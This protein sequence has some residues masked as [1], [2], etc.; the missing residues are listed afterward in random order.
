MSCTCRA[1]WNNP[2]L[3]YTSDCLSCLGQKAT[4]VEMIKHIEE[5]ET[6]QKDRTFMF[7][8]MVTLQVQPGKTDEAVR[9]YRDDVISAARK[10]KGFKGAQLL[11]DSTTGK[12]Y[13]ITQWETEADMKAGE[14]SGYYQEQI[15]KFG[16]ILKSTPT[17]E[18]LMVSI[19]V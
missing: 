8:R 7:S 14:A 13:S 17:R 12:A 18:G 9:I 4:T 6:L 16:Q 15:N 19:Q 5:H 11:T 10:Q 1:Y 3:P 2:D